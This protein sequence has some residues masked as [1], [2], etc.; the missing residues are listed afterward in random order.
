MCDCILEAKKY[1]KP[2]DSD[3]KYLKSILVI[4]YISSPVS[5]ENKVRI[6]RSNVVPTSTNVNQYYHNAT[7][8]SLGTLQ[9]LQIQVTFQ[10]CPTQ[11]AVSTPVLSSFIPSSTTIA[12]RSGSVGHQK[13]REEMIMLDKANMYILTLDHALSDQDK[14]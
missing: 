1:I 10:I 8:L 14:A 2:N 13:I 6:R 12:C 11:S 7:I 4:T 3:Y 9:M 5:N